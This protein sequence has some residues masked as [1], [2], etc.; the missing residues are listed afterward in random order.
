[1]SAESAAAV[2]PVPKTP[3]EPPHPATPPAAVD[4]VPKSPVEPAHPATP[5]AA[6]DPV[7]KPLTDESHPAAPPEKPAPATPPAKTPAEK[8]VPEAPA[9]VPA[10]PSPESEKKSLP[11]PTEKVKPAVEPATTPALPPKDAALKRA[12]TL[13]PAV[14]EPPAPV[15]GPKKTFTLPTGETLTIVQAAVPPVPPALTE[16]PKLAPVTESPVTTVVADQSK[17]STVVTAVKEKIHEATAPSAAPAAPVVVTKAIPVIAS[18]LPVDPPHVPASA[19]PVTVVPVTKLADTTIIPKKVDEVVVVPAEVIRKEAPNL[20]VVV[21]KPVLIVD[22]VAPAPIVPVVQTVEEVP[23]KAT[24]ATAILVPAESLTTKKPAEMV[25]A[26]SMAPSA[27]SLPVMTPA[28]PWNQNS[29]QN[30]RETQTLSTLE[31]LRRKIAIFPEY[32]AQMSTVLRFSDK[33]HHELLDGSGHA[34]FHLHH[35]HHLIDEHGH[36]V[37]CVHKSMIGSR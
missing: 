7:P 16:K 29:T 24:S 4:P 14:S 10:A 34:I 30:V 28:V 11:S 22:K 37:A 36:L 9:V 20:P 25:V 27:S 21:E 3:V 6:A 8:T 17:A 23:V 26:P 32:V 18:T 33:F 13:P 5:P 35:R 12:T 2:D 19:V 15:P 31:P 1:M